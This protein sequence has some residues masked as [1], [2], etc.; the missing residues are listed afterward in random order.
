MGAFFTAAICAAASPI[1]GALAVAAVSVVSRQEAVDQ[2]DESF[3]PWHQCELLSWP[4]ASDERT[5]NAILPFLTFIFCNH[6][7]Q[8]GVSFQLKMP[9]QHILHR[10]TECILN[11]G[12][13]TSDLLCEPCCGGSVG[14]NQFLVCLKGDEC[15]LRMLGEEYGG[16]VF[17]PVSYWDFPEDLRDMTSCVAEFHL[18]THTPT[19]DPKCLDSCAYGLDESGD[20]L[21]DCEATGYYIPDLGTPFI[22]PAQCASND[23]SIVA[24]ID[25]EFEDLGDVDDPFA[26]NSPSC[27]PADARVELESGEKRRM[28]E[29]KIGDSVLVGRQ[30]YSPIYAFTHKLK[31]A[32]SDFVVITTRSGSSLRL[33][34]GHFLYVQGDLLPALHV[35]V[36]D[37]LTLSDGRSS[38]VISVARCPHEAAGLY[39]PQTLHGDIVVD[40][41][42]ASTYTT[43]VSPVLAHASLMPLRVLHRVFALTWKCLETDEGIF[44][45]VAA[46]L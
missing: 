29:L 13:G 2:I 16:R 8:T 21:I 3:T 32:K 39:N 27:F 36:G 35:R 42:L 24:D 23:D 20:N 9:T 45:A 19:D 11:V 7:F 40:G 22:S 15:C 38:A 10:C 33:T 30:V 46:Y 44:R 34:P 31:R 5:A 18:A 14:G 4:R 1:F 26:I 37:M 12:S 17:V 25:S 41:I 43:A 6:T 28:D